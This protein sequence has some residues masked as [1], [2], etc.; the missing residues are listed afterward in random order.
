M[1]SSDWLS[2]CNLLPIVGI[3]DL[4]ASYQEHGEA[5]AQTGKQEGRKQTKVWNACNM[6]WL[7]CASVKYRLSP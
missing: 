4:G 3:V 1:N 6:V 7:A 2:W 5:D